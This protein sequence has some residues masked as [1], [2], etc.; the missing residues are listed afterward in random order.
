MIVYQDMYYWPSNDIRKLHIYLPN[1]YDQTNE[2][3]PVM[4]MFDGHNLYHDYEATYGK[5]WGL[6]SFLDTWD[7]KMI[8]VGM[9]CSHRGD[10]RLYEYCPYV[11][12]MFGKTI[13]GIGDQ[14]F[15]WIMHDIKP[16]IDANFRTY[17]HREATA[18]AGSSMGGIMSMYGVL[19]YNDVFSKAAVISSGVFR[20]LKH[21]RN[22]LEDKF[23]PDTKIYISWG[24]LEAGKAAY[25]GNPEFDTRE[26]RSVYKFEKELQTKGIQTY[27]YFQKD[28]KH[29]EV[30]WE[31]QNQI[32]LNFLWK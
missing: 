15:Q 18:I 1:E 11:K 5:S 32:Y 2:R 4:Y 28:G 20:N 7:K 16:Y 31:K 8:V 10:E 24:E 22:T 27:H 30:D 25:S 13:N 21:Y 12:R 14:T 23:Y 6:E 26:A 3:Y 17:G 19:K 29:C 9:E